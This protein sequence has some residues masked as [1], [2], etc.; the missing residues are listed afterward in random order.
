[1][2]PLYTSENSKPS[3]KLYGTLSVFWR[4]APVAAEHWLEELKSLTEK[5]R[6][7]HLGN[8]IWGLFGALWRAIRVPQGQAALPGRMWRSKYWNAMSSR[9]LISAIL[10]RKRNDKICRVFRTPGD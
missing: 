4:D 7:A 1:M 5:G 10:R 2:T 8:T 9:L 6:R 3:F